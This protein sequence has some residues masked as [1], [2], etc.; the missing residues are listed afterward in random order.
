[1]FLRNFRMYFRTF[2]KY[3]IKNCQVL[4]KDLRNKQLSKYFQNI[5]SNYEVVL[6]FME[7]L[8]S[9]VKFRPGKNSN[10]EIFSQFEFFP[11]LNLTTDN[12][13]LMLKAFTNLQRTLFIQ[14]S[15][16]Q[17]VKRSRSDWKVGGSN[18]P[19]FRTFMRN[20]LSF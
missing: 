4:H 8:F 19:S 1:M 14:S 12:N 13:F 9:V 11:G 2:W 18:L 10:W 17:S 5:F 3:F 20:Q 7:Q 6:K 16:A 15:V